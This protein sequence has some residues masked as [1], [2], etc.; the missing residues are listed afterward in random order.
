MNWKTDSSIECIINQS[1]VASYRVGLNQW[2]LEGWIER[3]NYPS[4]DYTEY[5]HSVLKSV[6]V[7]NLL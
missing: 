5:T 4:T 6:D 3:L 1:L 7:T 2:P